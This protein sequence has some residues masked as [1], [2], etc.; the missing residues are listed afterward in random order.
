[1]WI[2]KGVALISGWRLFQARRLIEEIRYVKLQV[3]Y[4]LRAVYMRRITSF[5]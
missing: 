3:I 2:P 5:S 1:M 4:Y